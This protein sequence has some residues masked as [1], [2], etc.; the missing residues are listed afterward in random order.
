MQL[1]LI[2]SR[3]TS[4]AMIKLVKSLPLCEICTIKFSVLLSSLQTSEFSNKVA[5]VQRN[6]DALSE[7]KIGDRLFIVK[8]RT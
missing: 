2:I 1:L 8:A 4:S 5:Q 7:I 6:S 3:A